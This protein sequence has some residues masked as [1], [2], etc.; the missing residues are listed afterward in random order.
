[1]GKS[2]TMLTVKGTRWDDPDLTIPDGFLITQILIDG[3]AGVDT[4]N[5]SGYSAGVTI[6]LNSGAKV[7]SYVTPKAFTGLFPD[8]VIK[9]SSTVSGTIR[10]VECLIGTDFNDALTIT[11]QSAHRL[12]D[13]GGGNDRLVVNGSGSN[14][15]VGGTG[16]DWIA[17]SGSPTFV[18]GTYANGVATRDGEADYFLCSA[19]V[20]ILDFEVG[21]D[22]LII[23]EDNASMQ[24]FLLSSSWQAYGTSGSALMLNG[25]AEI[26]LSDVPLEL[27]R[28][29]ELGFTVFAD[30]SGRIEG[31]S[32]DDILWSAQSGTAQYVFGA[33]SGNDIAASFD[34]LTDVLLFEDGIVP[35]WSDTLVNGAPALLGT[36]ADGSVTIQGLD[37]GDVPQL[38]VQNVAG[39]PQYGA[40]GPGPWS[41][42]SD[43]SAAVAT[44]VTG[45]GDGEAAVLSAALMGG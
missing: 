16:S 44:T 6:G 29:I 7:V 5:L 10:N 36:W 2:G 34:I 38:Q 21:I 31:S 3:G 33:N 1:M 26:I 11:V 27:A 35:V 24:A 28:G 18:G 40:S 32:G 22:R 39:A 41:A 20:T 42:A 4:L 19:P 45:A 13:G 30:A 9:D 14:L 43:Y 37:T 8:Y 23:H 15:V 12:L 17:S 25:V